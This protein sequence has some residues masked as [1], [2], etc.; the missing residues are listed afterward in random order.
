[1]V[2]GMHRSGTS[3]AAR[4]LNLLGAGL[5]ARLMPPV[6]GI[7][8]TGFW[9]STDVV[10]LNDEILKAA[11][12]RWD[13]FLPLPGDWFRS[14]AA[15]PYLERATALLGDELDR[16]PFLM[17]KDPRF[18]RLLS[19]WRPAMAAAG[20]RAGYVHVLR[21]PLEV[22]HSLHVRDGLPIAWGLVLWLRYVLVSER[23][24]RGEPRSFVAYHGLLHDWR[25]TAGRVARE[26]RFRWPRTLRQASA[27][28]DAFLRTS[29]RH[30]RFTDAELGDPKVPRLVSDVHQVLTAPGKSRAAPAAKPL[31]AS[32][33]Q[34]GR[35]DALYGELLGPARERG[36]ALEEALEDARAEAA[37]LREALGTTERLLETEKAERS[38][39][40]EAL[41]E[42]ER[43]LE[44]ERARRAEREASL[45]AASRRCS[46]LA[47]ERDAWATRAERAEDDARRQARRTAVRDFEIRRLERLV[48]APAQK[49]QRVEASRRADYAAILK[50]IDGI[51]G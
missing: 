47:A 22:A 40:R 5:P 21:H 2:L 35:A 37:R 39:L 36:W 34:L 9:E 10:G 44:S 48:A 38:R 6:E 20:A 26:L 42:A 14:P 16:E 32:F 31:D 1:M 28:V 30:H 24:T 18:C 51:A 11:G 50:A 46:H 15:R 43:L 4:V 7:N 49:L 3:A 25:R 27:G 17:L 33:E 13:D 23:E 8:E 19:I 45:A 41:G 12:S 29:L